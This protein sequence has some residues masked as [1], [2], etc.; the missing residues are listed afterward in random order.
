MGSERQRGLLTAGDL[1]APKSVS[2]PVVDLVLRFV[3]TVWI[4]LETT[5]VD[6]TSAA[7]EV[8]PPY[9]VHRGGTDKNAGEPP[10]PGFVPRGSALPPRRRDS[11]RL[12]H[13]CR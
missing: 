7:K 12:S 6:K 1:F 13:R 4:T 10:P 8:Q 3:R 11:S 9:R 5:A 2:P